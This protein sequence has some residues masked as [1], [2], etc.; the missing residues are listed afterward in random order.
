M[1]TSNPF[2]GMNPFLEGSWPDVHTALIGFIRETLA[3]QL[4]PDLSA[5]AEEEVSVGSEDD[6]LSATY[7]ADVAVTAVLPYG[8]PDVWQSGAESA[9]AVAEPEIL[10]IEHLPER[11]VEIRDTHGKLITVI[12]VLS[13]TNKL[14]YGREV[15][16]QKQQD[17]LAAG[18]NLVEIDL[19]RVGRPVFLENIVQQLSPAVG[20]RYLVTATR[21]R[22]RSQ[23]EVY[24]CAFREPLPTIRIPLRVTDADVALELQPLIDRVYR[25]GRYWQ[26]SHRDIP[27]PEL[28][29]VDADWAIERLRQAGLR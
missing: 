6:E 26:I 24:Y 29:P 27:A 11:W 5:R 18:V 7:R 4:P 9:V 17:Y 20:T 15:Y 16:V 19:L 13:P 28:P 23:M 3:E 25:T 12:E 2:P 8:L 21:A 10:E 22:R 1:Q 14:G